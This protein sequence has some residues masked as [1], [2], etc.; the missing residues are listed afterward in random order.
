MS[1]VSR[2]SLTTNFFSYFNEFTSLESRLELSEFTAVA[3]AGAK[4]ARSNHY[5]HELSRKAASLTAPRK[6][7]FILLKDICIKSRYSLLTHLCKKCRHSLRSIKKSLYIILHVKYK[8]GY[9]CPS[10]KK[11]MF[12]YDLVCN[13]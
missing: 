10:N 6:H 3:V 5:E 2:G 4:A 8:L 13:I 11:L 1:H 7:C 9:H 12:L